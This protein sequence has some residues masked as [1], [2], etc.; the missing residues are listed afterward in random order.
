MK[1]AN[2]YFAQIL[3]VHKKLISLKDEEKLYYDQEELLKTMLK[4]LLNRDDLLELS[5]INFIHFIS[6]CS[7]YRP[8]EPFQILVAV[9]MAHDQFLKE[10]KP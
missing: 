6:L 2:Q 3:K 4:T 5:K 1:T 9:S 10:N 8:R 7:S